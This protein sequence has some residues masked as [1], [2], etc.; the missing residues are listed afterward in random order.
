MDKYKMLKLYLNGLLY[1]ATSSYLL[2]KA[3]H[4]ILLIEKSKIIYHVSDLKHID[5]NDKK[6]QSYLV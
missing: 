2:W 4:Y 3:R 6:D 1:F 5:I